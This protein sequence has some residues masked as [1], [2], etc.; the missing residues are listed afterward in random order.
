MPLN[1][2]PHLGTPKMERSFCEER[3]LNSSQPQLQ[4]ALTRRVVSCFVCG[5]GEGARHAEPAGP[6]WG[7]DVSC[8]QAP[9]TCRG[10]AHVGEQLQPNPCLVRPQV[11]EVCCTCLDFRF[12]A[13]DWA[14]LGRL[15]ARRCVICWQ[16]RLRFG[17]DV[18][19][20]DACSRHS[21]HVAPENVAPAQHQKGV[22]D[23]ADAELVVMLF[24]G[25]LLRA[26][27]S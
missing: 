2:R 17:R 22:A 19:H 6:V 18:V 13:G 12:S 27:P 11:E 8:T 3:S 14:G 26:P 7:E 15:G 25:H 9:L 10:W 5:A 20:L 4:G 1:L 23:M 24:P 16:L 21:R